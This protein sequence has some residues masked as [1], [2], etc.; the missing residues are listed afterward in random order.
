LSG[1]IQ[2]GPSPTPETIP[3]LIIVDLNNSA[4]DPVKLILKLKGDPVTRAATVLAFVSHVQQEL[5]RE[6]EK[7][8][9]DLVLPRLAFSQNLY[10]I[11]RQR[12]CH[13]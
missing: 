1:A 4:L 2:D 13:L 3:P 8:G 9:A 6:A 11:L 7:A 12:S 10:E 5:K